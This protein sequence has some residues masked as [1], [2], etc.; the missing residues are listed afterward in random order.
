MVIVGGAD[1]II[2]PEEMAGFNALYAISIKNDSPEKRKPFRFSWSNVSRK[3]YAS[4]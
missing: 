1:S 3:K 2:N 4:G